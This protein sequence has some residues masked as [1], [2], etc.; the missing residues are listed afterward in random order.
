M[1]HVHEIA[2]REVDHLSPK[3]LKTWSESDPSA[4]FVQPR[5]NYS[6]YISYE[7]DKFRVDCEHSALVKRVGAQGYQLNLDRFFL[8]DIV[9]MGVELGEAREEKSER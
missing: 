1:R 3:W 9:V 5:D 8:V 7:F 6:K 4:A 2:H